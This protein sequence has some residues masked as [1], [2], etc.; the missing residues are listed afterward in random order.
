MSTGPV[1]Q[2]DGA[3]H[4]WE[5]VVDCA[6]PT[7]LATFYAELCGCQVHGRG[8]GWAWIEPATRGGGA[9]DTGGVRIAFQQ[10]P[11]PKSTKV[12]LHL[13]LGAADID[14]TVERAVGLGATQLGEPVTDEAGTF[15]VLAD[16]EGHEFCIVDA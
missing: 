11:E 7:T 6:D 1:C 3:V 13:D 8:D 2:S 5:I 12:R 9:A 16:P 15:V 14:A 4:L 10:V